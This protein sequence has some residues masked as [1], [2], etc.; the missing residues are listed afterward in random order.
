MVRLFIG[1]L[2]DNVRPVPLVYVGPTVASDVRRGTPEVQFAALDHRRFPPPPF[3]VVWEKP[4]GAVVTS[5]R[6]M[7]K[8]PSILESGVDPVGARG[9]VG[10]FGGFIGWRDLQVGFLLFADV[11]WVI[12]N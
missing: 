9:V 4:R 3:H 7:P 10:V 11:V 12:G 1:L 2:P 6:P 5:A 8:A